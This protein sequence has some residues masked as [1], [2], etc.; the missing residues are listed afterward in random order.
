MGFCPCILL[1]CCL[2]FD[3]SS[4]VNFPLGTIKSKEEEKSPFAMSE[5]GSKGQKSAKRF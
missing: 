4:A 3:V 2:S 1:L 5:F